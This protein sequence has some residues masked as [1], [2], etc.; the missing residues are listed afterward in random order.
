MIYADFDS[1]CCVLKEIDFAT[2]KTN[3]L[4]NISE[5]LNEHDFFTIARLDH[6][7]DNY[8]VVL[9]FD[10]RSVVCNFI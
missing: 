8:L 1:D 10:E 4:L 9:D 3:Q 2:S 5:E 6:I 7:G